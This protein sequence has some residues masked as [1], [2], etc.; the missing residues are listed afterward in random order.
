METT[1]AIQPHNAKA[2]A[3][4]GSGGHNYDRISYSIADGIEHCVIRLDP[5]PGERVLDVATGTGWAA[6]S[7]ARRGAEVTGIDL[8]AELIE[9][10]KAEAEKAGLPM[11]LQV[12]DA[13]A[14]AFD[15]RSFDA[16]ISTYGVMFAN[17]PEEAAAELARVCR[18]A[19]RVALATWLPDS[20]VVDLF[21]VMKP[22]MTVPA[23]PP[24]SPFE[25]GRE[26]RVRQLLGAHFD[27]RFET[28]NTTLRE[29]D[30]TAVWDLFVESYGPTKALAASLD[31]DRLKQL[32]NDFIAF[33]EGFKTDLGIAMRRDYLITIGVRK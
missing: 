11:D 17:R 14:L 9:G 5:K 28:G 16:V 27:L 31:A 12:G 33:H 3:T 15:D 18:K 19:G 6:R 26:D 30:G 4:W 8:G 2:A 20:T 29:R 24:P 7:V 22:Y 32:R 10:A 13:E 25:W 23:L 21:K 1:A